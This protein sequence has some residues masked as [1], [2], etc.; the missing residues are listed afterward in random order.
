MTLTLR[1]FAL[2]S[3]VSISF[4]SSCSSSDSTDST[5]QTIETA[6]FAPSLGVNLAASTR[7]TNGDYIRDIVVGTG[8]LVTTG[9][10]INAR[11]DGWL[12]NGK[13]FDSNQAGGITFKLGS[14][15]VISG[16]DEGIP[17]MRV[18]GKRQIIIPSN[19]GYGAAGNGPIP[20]NAILVFNVEVMSSN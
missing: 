18:G 8:T 14:G 16:W 2:A 15:G 12:A 5:P 3:A 6:T 7:T 20:G 9:K 19:L 1:A 13:L 17:G 4:L 11:Y 10:T